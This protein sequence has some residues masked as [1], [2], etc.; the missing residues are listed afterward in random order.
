MS[1]RTGRFFSGRL[2]LGKHGIERVGNRRS[3]CGLIAQHIPQGEFAMSFLSTLDS[4][5]SYIG[6]MVGAPSISSPL[7]AKS[8]QPAST[9]AWFDAESSHAVPGKTLKNLPLRHGDDD[10]NGFGPGDRKCGNP[11][12]GSGQFDCFGDIA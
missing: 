7:D 3:S 9:E 5:I 2:L 6:F 8:P 12:P 4:V 1:I 11:A 10:Q